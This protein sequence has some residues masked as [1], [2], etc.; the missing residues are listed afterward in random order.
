MVVDS[1]REVSALSQYCDQCKSL[2]VFFRRP[3]VAALYKGKHLKRLLEQRWSG[4]LETSKIIISEFDEIC[5]T[6]RQ[7]SISKDLDGDIVSVAKGFL[8]TLHD[9]K[10]TFAAVVMQTILELISPADRVLQAR[11]TGLNSAMKIVS[12]VSDEIQQLRSQDAFETCK[13]KAE[14]MLQSEDLPPP[15][16]KRM[17]IRNA[18]FSDSILTETLGQDSDTE[19]SLRST[20]FE[21]VDCVSTEMERRF[22]SNESL[23]D[24]IGSITSDT[25]LSLERLQPLKELGIT[26]PSAEELSVV[27]SYLKRQGIPCSVM[28]ILHEL[29]RQREAF[30]DT[31]KL[32]ATVATFPCST[33]MCESSFSTLARIDHPQRRSMLQKRQAQLVMLAFE[34]NRTEKVELERFL[35]I[36]SKKTRKLQLY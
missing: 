36:F 31:Y 13:A 6:L 11:E 32:V 19:T 34:R 23:Y 17:C 21:A 7:A 8:V 9:I 29:F 27:N 15:R 26:L 18:K 1:F 24:A 3:K 20:Y 35:R 25:F 2:Y 14:G 28:A 22:R 4:H 10:F 12:V 33:A 30:P 16:E 5:S